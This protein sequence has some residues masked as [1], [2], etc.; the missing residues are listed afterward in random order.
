MTE[1]LLKIRLDGDSIGPG[2]IPVPHLISFLSDMMKA[3]QRTGR[4]LQGDAES[5]CRG[6]M[7]KAIKEEV[8]LELVLLTHGSPSVVLGFER[9]QPDFDLKNR[10]R[11]R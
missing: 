1:P 6:Q 4:V 8:S 3:L 10:K 11:L 5:R 7:P 9:S 2:R